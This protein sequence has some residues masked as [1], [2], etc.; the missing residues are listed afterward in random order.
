MRNLRWWTTAVVAIFVMAGAVRAA[1]PEKPPPSLTAEQKALDKTIRASLYHVINRGAD[2]YTKDEN[3]LGCYLYFQGALQAIGPLL[4]HHPEVQRLIVAGL[5]DADSKQMAWQ[6]AFRLR[7]L[8]DEVRAKLKGDTVAPPLANKTAWDRFG[9]EE[10]VTKIVKEFIGIAATDPKVDFTR[11]GKF[12]PTPEAQATLSRHMLEYFSEITGGP[13]KYSGK[14]MKE[15]HKDMGINIAEFDAA[16]DDLKKA[17]T[18]YGASAG[19]TELVLKAIEAT[20]KDIVV[21]K[22]PVETP[23]GKTLWDRLGGEEGVTKIVKDLYETVSKDPALKL[24]REGDP[25]PTPEQIKTLQD[26][27]VDYISSKTGGPRKYEGKTMKAA[28]AGMHITEQQF[29]VFVDDFKGIL[30]HHKIMP[31]DIKTLVDAVKATKKDIVE[32]K[33]PD[34]KPKDK[35]SDDKPKDKPNTD[36]STTDKPSTDKPKDKPTADKPTD[37]PAD[38]KAKDK[39]ADDKPKGDKPPTDK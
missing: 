31:D 2:I 25:K 16:V 3:P 38:D 33:K 17:L 32:V 8:L 29:D 39:P 34:D 12:N 9:G 23:V 1:D 37:K 24:F 10:G 6:Q 11:G 18:K 30:E 35:P 13:L 21:P 19:D 7:D 4:D 28:H 14:N 36:K 5:N 26:E 22:K 27:I 15:V 20:R